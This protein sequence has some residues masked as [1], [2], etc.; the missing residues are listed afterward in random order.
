MQPGDMLSRIARK[1][2]VSLEALLAANRDRIADPDRI[3]PGQALRAPRGKSVRETSKEVDEEAQYHVVREGD[4]LLGIASRFGLDAMALWQANRDL[5]ED[6][7]RIYP[8][9]RLRIPRAKR[10]DN[11]TAGNA[12][13][14]NEAIGRL[15]RIIMSEAGVG[16]LAE[17]IAVGWVAL[18][19][20]LYNGGMALN[21]EPTENV[22]H[23]ALQIL[24]GEVPDN[25][26]GATHFY[27]PRSMPK[28]GEDTGPFDTKGGLEKIGDHPRNYR[29]GWSLILR[30]VQVPGTREW[31]FKF[32]K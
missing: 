26:G 32:Y 8:G 24:T 14:K 15:A 22:S 9:Q 11:E 21:Q 19:R 12:G 2:G 23:L 25:T 6:P 17:R 31:Y 29:P 20:G 16:T 18:N 13:N 7:D 27:S 4:T 30:Q 28:E 1:L 5:L 3:Y 10:A